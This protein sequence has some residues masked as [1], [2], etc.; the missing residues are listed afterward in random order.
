MQRDL[1]KGK[2]HFRRQGC[3]KQDYFPKTLQKTNICSMINPQTSHAYANCCYNWTF[4]EYLEGEGEL[5]LDNFNLNL[6]QLV[7]AHIPSIEKP[8]RLCRI[9]S[10][11]CGNPF[12]NRIKPLNSFL[13]LCKYYIYF[14]APIGRR[15]QPF[16][17]TI[18]HQMEAL[19]S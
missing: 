3:H 8:I 10:N 5:V 9:H 16:G 1:N 4:Q 6:L 18:S 17:F 2:C 19:T 11:L 14:I 13:I 7:I 12:K 15:P